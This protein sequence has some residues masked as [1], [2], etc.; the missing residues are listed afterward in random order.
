MPR[1][2]ETNKRNGHWSNHESTRR[3]HVDGKAA[4][5]AKD[6]NGWLEE[7]AAFV[8]TVVSGVQSLEKTS[9]LKDLYRITD[10]L[11]E[12]RIRKM[13]ATF[14]LGSRLAVHDELI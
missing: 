12:R 9:W 2:Q 7:P 5:N 13:H 6:R 10:P 8:Q 3:T 14:G 1:W 11:E 4:T